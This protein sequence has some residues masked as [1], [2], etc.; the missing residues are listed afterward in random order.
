MQNAQASPSPAP[1]PRRSLS[2]SVYSRMVER[3]VNGDYRVGDRLPPE[4]ELALSFSVS[5][6]TIRQ[7]LL[8]LREC[9]LVVSLQGSGN[10]VGGL[11]LGDI[12]AFGDVLDQASSGDL[13]DFRV[14]LETQAAAMAAERRTDSH[15]ESMQTALAAHQTQG[16][17][18]HDWLIRYR[19]A[20]LEFHEA[21]SD[22]SGNPMVNRLLRSINPLFTMA[23]LSWKSDVDGEFLLIAGQVM[24]EH[25]MI[26]RAIAAHDSDMARVAMQF[27]MKH[28]KQRIVGRNALLI[29]S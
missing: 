2:Y 21:V 13:F 3:I 8:K 27:H 22:A 9:R 14:G 15:L 5:R 29:S 28:A 17:P 24:N 12:G 26:M 6:V 25:S 11:P 18:T 10:Y 4:E 7:A 16:E 19:Q 1:K 20:D 23:W